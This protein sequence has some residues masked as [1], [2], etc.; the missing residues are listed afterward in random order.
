VIAVTVTNAKAPNKSVQNALSASSRLAVTLSVIYVAVR[1]TAGCT[2]PYAR[3]IQATCQS[4]FMISRLFL[5]E[6][7]RSRRAQ[8]FN[9]KLQNG[10][11]MSI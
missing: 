5:L 1:Q 8:A 3:L 10:G 6:Q 2:A 7:V 9:V 11:V 4:V